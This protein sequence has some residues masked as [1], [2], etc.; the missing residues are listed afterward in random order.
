MRTFLIDDEPDSIEVMSSL[1]TQYFPNDITIIGSASSADKGYERVQALKPDLIFLDIQMPRENGFVFLKK[2]MVIDF[3]IIFVTSHDQYALEAIK[4][5]ALDYLLKPVMLSDLE[6]AI[7]KAKQ[8][9]EQKVFRQLQVLNLIT[10]LELSEG[11]RK[12]AVHHGDEVRFL[13][14]SDIIYFEA[15]GRYTKIYPV[16]G[17]YLMISN[18]LKILNETLEETGLFV[19]VSKSC[20]INIDHIVSYT[21]NEPYYIQLI[22]GKTFELARRKR[23]EVLDKLKEKK[24][25][26]KGR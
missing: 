25:Q 23:Q 4:F 24:I 5:S 10:D 6:K 13:K 7:A 22:N 20:L 1:L 9:V 26:V 21:K 15:M 16:S 11:S 8:T 2:F 14:L 12:I 17:D 3:E 19:R 18:H